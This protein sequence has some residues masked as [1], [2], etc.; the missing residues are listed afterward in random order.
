ML[1]RHTLQVAD[2]E[3]MTGWSV[4]WDGC[5]S[6]Y[7]RFEYTALTVLGSAAEHG[8][9]TTQYSGCNDLG[10]VGIDYL[11]RHACAAAQANTHCTTLNSLPT[12]DM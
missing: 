5:Q 6:D 9:D 11:D 3:V 2:T 10:E 8:A 12:A 7:F 1:D 4:G